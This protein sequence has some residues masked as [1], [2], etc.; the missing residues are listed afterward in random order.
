M[1]LEKCDESA[2]QAQMSLQEIERRSRSDC[3][4][5]QVAKWIANVRFT[6]CKT[7]LCC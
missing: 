3:V 6:F 1:E 2:A 7:E 4:H 5:E